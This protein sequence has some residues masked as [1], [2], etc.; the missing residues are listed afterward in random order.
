MPSRDPRVPSRR[1]PA[2][3]AFVAASFSGTLAARQ[4]QFGQSGRIA[5][6]PPQVPQILAHR[7]ARCRRTDVPEPAATEAIRF[8]VNWVAVKVGGAHQPALDIVLAA[9]A[10]TDFTS[11]VRVFGR[12][13]WLGPLRAV[14]ATGISSHVF[15]FDGT[16]LA[17]I[18]H[19]A[20]PVASVLF[21]LSQTHS[22]IGAEWLHAFVI[23]VEI[24][25]RPGRAVFPIHYEMGWHIT[26]TCG[27]FGAAAAWAKALHLDAAGTATALRIAA[28]ETAGLKIQFGSMSKSLNMGR[29]AEN[30]MLAAMLAR[31]RDRKPA[32]APRQLRSRREVTN[33]DQG[34]PA[35][36]SEAET[37]RSR[38]GSR[39]VRQRR[40]P[41]QSGRDSTDTQR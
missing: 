40:R 26:E 22:M 28:T 41:C 21:A 14:L 4:E 10:R 7:A 24:E 5:S 31:P 11:G 35:V 32:A 3:A 30:G 39:Q 25:G 18:I 33:T 34:H 38:L 20:G 29:G 27:E 1:F 12:A 37:P 8:L 19:P 2:G 36:G 6:T 16:D 23:G 17:T 13:E 15:D 9:L